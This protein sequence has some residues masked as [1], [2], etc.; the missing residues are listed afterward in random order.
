[1]TLPWESAAKLIRLQAM[2]DELLASA[3]SASEPSVS[4]AV[5]A[6]LEGLAQEVQAVLETGDPVLAAEFE[7][8]VVG[9]SRD[10]GRPEVVGAVVSGW[11]RAA[12]NVEALAEKRDAAAQQQQPPP[13]RKQTIGF[14]IRSPIT[15]EPDPVE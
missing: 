11:L 8:V 13:R 2:S 4:K 1:M 5:M 10:S 12:L 15:R 3:R 7:R 9:G 6:S 14:K